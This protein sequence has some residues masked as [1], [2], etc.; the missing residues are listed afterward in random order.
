MKPSFELRNISKSFPGVQALAGVSLQFIPGEIHAL[1]GEN[2]AGKSTLMKIATGIHQPDEGEIFLHGKP[3]RFQSYRDSIARGVYLVHQE[4][5]VVPESTVAE[6]VMLDKLI[7]TGKARF[8]DW[9]AVNAEAQ[10]YTDMVGLDLPST[11][12]VKNLSGAQKQLIQIAKALAANAQVVLLDEPTSTLSQ[13]EALKLQSL[14]QVLAQKG[15]TL[16]YISHKLEEILS[17]CDRLSVLR[18]GHH[19]ATKPMKDLDRSDIVQMMIG[20]AARAERLGVLTSTGRREMLRAQGLAKRGKVED[21]SF[22]LYSGEILGFYGLVGAGRTETAR[23]LIGDDKLD[24]GEISIAGRRVEIRS[25]G[26]SLRRLRLGYATENRKEEGLLL[27]APVG[28]NLTITIWDRIQ[29]KWTWRIDR[30]KDRDIGQSMITEMSIKC[31]GLDETAGNLSGGNQQKICLGKWL[32]ADCEILIIDEPTVG[33]DIGA[34]EQIHQLIWDLAAKKG[35]AILLISSDMPEVIKLA[36]RILVFRDHH[37]VGEV[38]NVE[39]SY[40]QT[41]QAIGQYLH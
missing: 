28:T 10:K 29:N 17:L 13:H 3:A 7:T 9:R 31:R 40:E 25:I 33:V 24:E 14:L 36:N 18:D 26:D 15:T 27:D 20:R 35:K 19:I 30:K 22:T 41:S 4:I 8:I 34:K 16:I 32:A 23:L 5:Q 38:D 2:G 39:Q 11:N 37:I 1:V 21:V 12:L 6:N